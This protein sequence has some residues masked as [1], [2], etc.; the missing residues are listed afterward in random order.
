[1]TPPPVPRPCVRNPE[2]DRMAVA[3]HGSLPPD[4]RRLLA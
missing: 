4:V 1:M 2:T 3:W